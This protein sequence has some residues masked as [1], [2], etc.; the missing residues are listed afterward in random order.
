M[1][2]RAFLRLAVVGHTNTGKTSLLRTLTRDPGFGEVQDS[3]GTTRRVEGARLLIDD[4]TAVELFD[5]PGMEDGIALLDYLDQLA[6]RAERLDGP[7]RI[8][9]FLNSPESKRRFEQEARVLNKLLDCDAGLYVIDVRDPVLGKHK[10]E[11]AILASCGQPLLPVLN[12]THS[13]HQRVD[14]WREALARLGL[15]AIVEFDTIAPPLDGEA[16]LYDKLA[17]LLDSHAGLLKA[18]KHDIA[19][20]RDIRRTDASRLI[21]ELLVD[22][23]AW[24]L[25]SAPDDASILQ[26]TDTLRQ[27]IRQRENQ[28]VKALLKRYNFRSA[29]FP[30]H[31]LPLEGERWGMDLFHPQ[32]VKD[33][34]IHVGKGVA[35]G[36]AAGATIDIFTAGLS[37]GAAALAG[38]AVG[39]LWQGA[40]RF[41]KRLLGRLKGY[42]ELSVDDTVLRLLAVR[43]A[44]LVQALEQRGH[45]AQEP[46]TLPPDPDDETLSSGRQSDHGFGT[47]LRKGRLPAELNEARSQPLWSTLAD[48]YSPTPRREQIIRSLAKKLA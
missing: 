12:F 45:A 14:A 44:S 4:E 17:L 10:D 25:G 37:L 46:I 3:P 1:T 28:C 43:Q 19:Q 7:D 47:A 33:M 38:A 27:K 20:Q 13:P 39:G 24:H 22:V 8:R 36:A 16:Q 18:L 23:A 41:G 48:D 21:A 31:A 15:H 9:R 35:A 6:Q 26:A 11:L 29:D 32:A 2:E 34:G 5:T 40:D 30:H 42:R